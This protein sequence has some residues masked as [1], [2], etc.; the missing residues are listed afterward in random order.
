MKT[1][2]LIA[3]ALALLPLAAAAQDVTWTVI[4]G[5]DFRVPMP[6]LQTNSSRSMDALY[7][8]HAGGDR[9][10]FWQSGPDVDRGLWSR[11][12]GA[13]VRYMQF[14][15]TGA[16][17]PGR[18][19]TNHVFVERYSGYEDVAAD[20][21]RVFLARAGDPAVAATLSNGVWSWVGGANR[22][23]AR[24]VEPGTLGPGLGP[25]W[26]IHGSS[27][28]N[29]I[30]ALP[31]GAAMVDATVVA[32]NTSQQ[33]VIF[34]HTPQGGNVPCAL[35]NSADAA[36]SPG[37]TAGDT[38][39]RWS[40]NTRV[41]TVDAQGRIYGLLTVSGSRVGIFELC[42]GAPRALAVDEETGARGPGLAS[43]NGTFIDFYNGALHGGNGTFHFVATARE[44]PGGSSVNGIFRNDGTRNRPL[45][46]SGDTGLLSPHWAG[47]VFMTFNE[48]TLDA[49]GRYI[50]FGA[51]VNAGGQSIS[52]VFRA[53]GS[54]GPQPVALAGTLEY[55]PGPGLTWT[56][57][58]DR[59]VFANGDI[60]MLARSSDSVTAL[61]LFQEGRPARKILAPGQA[62]TLPTSTG[63]VQATINSI[64]LPNSG[65][66]GAQY[67]SSRDGWA[68]P[69]GT[70]LV[71]TTVNGYDVWLTAKPSD[72]SDHVFKDG[73]GG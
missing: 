58:Y 9:W 55:N 61:W 14:N 72:P 5:E 52:G 12:N 50:V 11:R 24:A 28:F 59:T 41:R 36:L 3:G 38:F 48:D 39:A 51:S 4:A 6:P 37:I 44:A 68:S 7:L 15:A 57:F 67:A 2:T 8:A 66:Y 18:A 69:D 30:R 21:S 1:T 43:P 16:T 19:G 62:F 20:G 42:N 26:Y 45:A 46:L 22:E 23:I 25:G 53:G 33:D 49:S 56:S 40:S 35:S 29:Q 64:E 34:K 63:P 13:L 73:F 10:G 71:R 60:V 27:G 31:I 47:S 54:N 32:P 70:V 17:G 65:G